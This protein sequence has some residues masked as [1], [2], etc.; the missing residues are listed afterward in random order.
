V[1]PRGNV[2]DVVARPADPDSHGEPQRASGNL[3]PTLLD[4]YR[5]RGSPMSRQCV[6]TQAAEGG[7]ARAAGMTV[8]SSPRMVAAA[9]AT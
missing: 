3:Q 7:F 9:T 5:E 4:A 1:P 2:E 6:P 8:P